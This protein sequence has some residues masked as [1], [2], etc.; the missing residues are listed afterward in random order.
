MARPRGKKVAAS[1]AKSLQDALEF[2]AVAYRE[3][4]APFQSHVILHSR[5]LHAFDGVIAAGCPIDDDL[6]AAPHGVRLR[7]ALARPGTG[8]SLTLAAGGDVLDVALGGFR[9]RVPCLDL[10]QIAPFG[11]DALAFPCDGRLQ[12][13]FAA[14]A[15]LAANSGTTVIESS[16]LLERDTVTATNRRLIMQIWHGL[17][18]PRS[19]VVPRAFAAA[20]CRNGRAWSGLGWSDTS[21]S[22]HFTDG[23]WL[24]T[25]LYAEDWPDV[26]A[27]LADMAHG[28]DVLPTGFFEACEAVRPFA[29]ADLPRLHVLD[30]R[31]ATGPDAGQAAASQDCSGLPLSDPAAVLPIELLRHLAG[32]ATHVDWTSSPRAVH[33]YGPDMRA[34][35][36][37]C[38]DNPIAETEY[39]TAAD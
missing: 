37:R 15:G 13:A 35:L 3:I 31:V 24:R 1:A 19:F 30:G 11:P 16:L 8:L 5:F 20:L 9:A 21:L 6:T 32:V 33:F 7:D 4:G 38:A 27:V 39:R 26:E 17:A 18:L 10:A 36:I 29:A 23:A 2:C 25:Q 34:A 12:E 28:G 14:V 22:V